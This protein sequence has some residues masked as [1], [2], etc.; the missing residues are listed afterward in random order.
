MRRHGR[1]WSASSCF[2]R[3]TPRRGA[4]SGGK[5]IRL[6]TAWAW[7][8]SGSCWKRSSPTIRPGRFRGVALRARAGIRRTGGRDPSD[9]APGVGRVA[10][11]PRFR[12]LPRVAG[13]R[14]AE[15][16][17]T[18]RHRHGAWIRGVEEG[19]AAF[20]QGAA[21]A[22]GGGPL[23]REGSAARGEGR[24]RKKDDGALG[25]FAPGGRRL[26]PLSEA[27]RRHP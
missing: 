16:R 25:S 19:G 7:R 23:P 3:P 4:A 6:R 1:R 8:S 2:R 12:R 17:L 5:G 11:R 18:A 13:R 10:V 9:G 26:P 20:A 14:R 22:A 24:G 21:T 15:R 27:H